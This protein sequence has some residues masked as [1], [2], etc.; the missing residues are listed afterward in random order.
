MAVEST[1]ANKDMALIEDRYVIPDHTEIRRMLAD[2][3]DVRAALLEAPAVIRDTFG[4]RVQGLVLE[5]VPDYDE[6]E[7][8]L[9]ATAL[10]RGTAREV[11]D[12]VQEFDKWWV[13]KSPAVHMAL[14]IG[15]VP[16]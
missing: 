2:R 5:V 15:A 10:V 16:V 8:L 12:L 9:G 11:F 14:T 1:V 13:T 7:D 6:G 3:P 4:S